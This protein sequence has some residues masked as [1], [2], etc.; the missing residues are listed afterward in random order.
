MIIFG[1]RFEPKIW[2]VT[3]T[4]IA[5]ISFVNLGQWQLSRASEKEALFDQ[6]EKY[7]KEPVVV[8]PGTTIKFSDFQYRDVEV[9][10]EFLTDKTIYL[11]NKTYKGLAGY[12]IVTP[13]KLS[14]SSMSVAINRG[15]VRADYDRAILPEIP[16][17]QGLVKVI[18]RVT[19]PEIKTLSLSNQENENEVWGSFDLQR[20]EDLTGFELQ[21]I[22]VLQ[23]D[24]EDDGLIR[25]WDKP[26]SGAAKNFGYA[27]QWFS[28]AV[29]SIII[30][31]ILNVKRN[32]TEI[33]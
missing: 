10:G 13:L 8:L 3:I 27:V 17:K 23:K 25:D 12:H 4:T 2:S 15:W 19:S 16:L 11:D 20:F 21:P 9:Y 6:I 24:K 29:T 22:M 32:I 18:G 5:V 28:L 26:E 14:N 31:I 33:K 30:F 1:Y 7:A